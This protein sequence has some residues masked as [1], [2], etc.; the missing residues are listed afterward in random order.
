MI[1]SGLASLSRIPNLVNAAVAN[2]TRNNRPSMSVQL[3]TR[4]T[5]FRLEEEGY[6]AWHLDLQSA[7][8]RGLETN[9]CGFRID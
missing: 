9:F 5:R 1:R 3:L 2:A 6:I 4:L 7:G 8:P